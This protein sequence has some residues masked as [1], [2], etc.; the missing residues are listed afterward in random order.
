MT[1]YELDATLGRL[2]LKG[3]TNKIDRLS[4]KRADRPA[5]PFS[6]GPGHV[7]SDTLEDAFR[8]WPG[9][10]ARRERGPPA[11]GQCTPP[12]FARSRA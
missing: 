11:G 2:K 8:Q 5:Q 9:A 10:Q 6:H 3:L 1:T 12:N 4:E 7:R